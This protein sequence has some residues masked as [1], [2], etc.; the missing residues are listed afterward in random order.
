MRK[1]KVAIIG[2]GRMGEF[3]AKQMPGEIEKHIVDTSLEKAKALAEAVGGSY[4]TDISDSPDIQAAAIVLPASAV[5]QMSKKLAENVPAGCVIMNLA[6]SGVIPDE[7]ISA[8]PGIVFVDCKIIGHATSIKQGAPSIVVVNTEDEPTLNTCRMLLS[9][10]GKVVSGDSGLVEKINTIGS[11][12]G[13]R[14]AVRVRKELQAMGIPE[15]WQD[16]V[17]YTVC[18]GTI[19]S[20]IEKDLGHFALELAEKL[21]SGEES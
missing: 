15:D 2:A 12:E 18:A 10:Y 8:N 21:E 4:S 17:I 6:T 19:R 9:G 11:K 7:V 14:A 16:V 3:V 1:M 5:A 20:Y 13:I